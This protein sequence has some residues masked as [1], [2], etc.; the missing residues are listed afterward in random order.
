MRNDILQSIMISISHETE[1]RACIE[2][3][4]LSL[5]TEG[6]SEVYASA[7]L[8]IFSDGVIVCEIMSSG[9]FTKYSKPV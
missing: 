7:K 6:K 1:D 2:I 3:C 4:L 9:D 8:N 5:G